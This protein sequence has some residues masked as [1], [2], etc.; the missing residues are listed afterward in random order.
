MQAPAPGKPN[1]YPSPA[2]T[3]DTR[4]GDLSKL[5]LIPPLRSLSEVLPNK[6]PIKQPGVRE[7]SEVGVN[8]NLSNKRSDF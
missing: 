5:L 8:L 3:L 6:L 4:I 2:I 7:G 1:F